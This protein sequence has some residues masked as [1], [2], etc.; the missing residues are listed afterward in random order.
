MK[1]N[2]DDIAFVAGARNHASTAEIIGRLAKQRFIFYMVAG[3]QLGLLGL[4]IIGH[5]VSN[6]PR[7]GGGPSA[8]IA[9]MIALFLA[10]ALHA[11]AKLKVLLVLNEFRNEK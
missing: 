2:K 11:D 8:M 1:P 6:T 5:F 9:L 10:F 4:D 3:L 7:A